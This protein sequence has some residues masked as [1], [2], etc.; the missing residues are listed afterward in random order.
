MV[1]AQNQT[2]K[3]TPKPDDRRTPAEKLAAKK[4]DFRRKVYQN[5][6]TRYNYYYNAKLKLENTLKGIQQQQQEN[7]NKLLPFT[8]TPSNR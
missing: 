8:R 4:F 6:V 3:S 7:Y 5:L 2:G 1:N